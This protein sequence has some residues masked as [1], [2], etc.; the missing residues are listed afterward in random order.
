MAAQLVVRG[1]ALKQRFEI[2]LATQIL[3]RH[4][5]AYF[6]MDE[7]K[8]A[9][10]RSRRNPSEGFRDA[11]RSSQARPE[12]PRRRGFRTAAVR[13]SHSSA[14]PFPGPLPYV[15]LRSGHREGSV[16]GDASASARAA[17]A[18]PQPHFDPRSARRGRPS[19]SRASKTP[20]SSCT[21]NRSWT[22]A[23]ISAAES[24]SPPRSKNAASACG[25]SHPSASCHNCATSSSVVDS[26]P[27]PRTTATLL[28]QP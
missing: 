27:V 19:V 3:D 5:Q 13:L 11:R 2:R 20:S 23:D 9:H 28:P 4:L 8:L 24:E 16:G 18:P 6:G 1:A 21:P 22:P 14:R 26:K 15:S 7:R 12:A 25:S 10:H 17:A